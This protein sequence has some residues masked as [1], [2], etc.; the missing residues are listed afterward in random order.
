[1]GRRVEGSSG[2]AGTGGCCCVVDDVPP[3]SGRPH[4]SS[5]RSWMPAR[6]AASSLL[7]GRSPPTTSCS[8][9]NS[10]KN[11]RQNKQEHGTSPHNWKIN[12]FMCSV[13]LQS[14]RNDNPLLMWWSHNA[15]SVAYCAT[16]NDVKIPNPTMTRE[17]WQ[18]T[19]PKGTRF[20]LRTGTYHAS[21]LRAFRRFR[22]IEQK[23]IITFVMS[24]CLSVCPS[25]CQSARNNSAPTG[26]ISNTFDI[27]ESSENL[28]RKFKFN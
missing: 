25:V 20:N 28:S 9:W 12:N 27:R 6:V 14:K 21:G 3:G 19:Y 17:I 8:S 26:R 18:R 10:K 7:H 15:T 4:D 11:C 23:A 1:M 22:K 2:D 5:I 13:V 24:V 16:C